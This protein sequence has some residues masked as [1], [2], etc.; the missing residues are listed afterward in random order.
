MDRITS[1]PYGDPF[2]RREPAFA[3]W[4]LAFFVTVEE[5]FDAVL[6]F[7]RRVEPGD[8]RGKTTEG[9]SHWYAHDARNQ[10]LLGSHGTD[11]PLQ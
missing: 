11:L 5:L 1:E 6:L 4:A 8:A 10:N 3:I 7:R 2:V 9:K